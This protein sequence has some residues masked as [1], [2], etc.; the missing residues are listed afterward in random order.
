MEDIFNHK[1]LC[2]YCDIEMTTKIIEKEGFKLRVK[3]CPECNETV[4]HPVD[5][6]EYKLFNDIRCKHF[7][8]KLRFVGNSYTVSI[9]KEIID[10]QEEFHKEINKLINMSLDHPEKLTLYFTKKRSL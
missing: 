6:Q 8:V 1:T 3:M 9:P 5:W 7:Q 4:Y 10:F 2:M